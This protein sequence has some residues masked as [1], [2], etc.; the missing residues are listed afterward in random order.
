MMSKFQAW[1]GWINDG[2]PDH[3]EEAEEATQFMGDNSTFLLDLM[4]CSD[5]QSRDEGTVG[6]TIW[7]MSEGGPS[8]HVQIGSCQY[9]LIGKNGG[10]SNREMVNQLWHTHS[11]DQSKE[12]GETE[13]RKEEVSLFVL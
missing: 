9:K 12:L 7:N 8:S 1:G 3:H 4:H 2:G 11:I 5:T 10:R 13:R 6:T